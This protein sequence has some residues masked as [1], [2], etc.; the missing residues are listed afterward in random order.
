MSPIAATVINPCFKNF[1]R[2]FQLHNSDI[3]G[4]LVVDE[5][6]TKNKPRS[7]LSYI[8]KKH[9]RLGGKNLEIKKIFRLL[10]ENKIEIKSDDDKLY[11]FRQ[12]VRS[13]AGENYDLE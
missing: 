11:F 13:F 10:I 3:E 5:E 2:L 12:V 6:L 4:L 7:L 9:V 1:K 8:C